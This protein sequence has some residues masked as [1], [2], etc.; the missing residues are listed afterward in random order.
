MIVGGDFGLFTISFI[1][2]LSLFCLCCRRSSCRGGAAFPGQLS[3]YTLK[4]STCS[5][6]KRMK[7]LFS[8]FFFEDLML[9][10]VRFRLMC[11]AIH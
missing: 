2:V 11:S 4:K 6:D 5:K 8:K 7:K 3:Y 9:E 10:R 1:K